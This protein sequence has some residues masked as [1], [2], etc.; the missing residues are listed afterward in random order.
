MKRDGPVPNIPGGARAAIGI[1]GGK[2]VI[3]GPKKELDRLRKNPA[4]VEMKDAVTY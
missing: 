4:I 1:L 3:R 2:L